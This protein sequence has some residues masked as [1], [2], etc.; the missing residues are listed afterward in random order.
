M[1]PR[2]RRG[3][4]F[5]ANVAGS[6]SFA[7]WERNVLSREPNCLA[8]KNQVGYAMLAGLV[9]ASGNSCADPP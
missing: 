8:N 1:I 9:L 7:P 2:P 5:I 3:Q 4:M 6:A